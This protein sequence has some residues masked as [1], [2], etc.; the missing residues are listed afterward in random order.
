MHICDFIE[1]SSHVSRRISCTNEIGS[2]EVTAIADRAN[3]NAEVD[4]LVSRGGAAEAG[5]DASP[6]EDVSSGEAFFLEVIFDHHHY[7]TQIHLTH[8][9]H[10]V[11]KIN[12]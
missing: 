11:H 3:A 6:N 5:G 2:N 1:D 4:G 7:Q 8:Q 10:V 12:T 9:Q